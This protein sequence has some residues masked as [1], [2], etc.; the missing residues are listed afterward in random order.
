[1]MIFDCIGRRFQLDRIV[2]PESIGGGRGGGHLDQAVLEAVIDLTLLRIV[3]IPAVRLF[4]PGLE[5]R[6]LEAENP[7]R[8]E[9]NM[10]FLRMM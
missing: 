2:S 8:L 1:M 4:E 9:P 3:Q 10:S 5:W 7:L 6:R